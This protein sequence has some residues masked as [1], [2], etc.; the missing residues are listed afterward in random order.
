MVQNEERDLDKSVWVNQVVLLLHSFCFTIELLA[1]QA[2]NSNQI[3]LLL[4]LL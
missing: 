2:S 4:P 1:F 3:V